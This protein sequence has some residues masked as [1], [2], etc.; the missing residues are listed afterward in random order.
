MFSNLTVGV[1]ALQGDFERHL[2]RLGTLGV[3][4]REVRNPHDLDNIDGL[5]IPG[6][7][8]TTM[9]L[10]IDRF[11]M[12]DKMHN[13][14]MNKGV[15]GTCAGMIML[16]RKVDDDRIRP[17]GVIDIS[18]M[19]NAYGRQVHSFHTS[20]PAQLNGAPVTLKASF[21]RAPAVADC[22][23]DVR[24]LAEYEKKP[25][26][27]AQRNCLVSSFHTELDDDLTLTK[28][29]LEKFVSVFK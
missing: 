5:I 4:G 10:L 15:S 29:Y 24:V 13:F 18:V 21:I 6:G 16:A 26:L 7:E 20:V 25:V 8:S 27:L 22:G 2:Y 19:R 11:G 14:C 28:Y 23:R 1:L 17:L 3:S 9:S 12:R